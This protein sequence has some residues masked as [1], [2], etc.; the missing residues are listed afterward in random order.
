LILIENSQ[1]N[2]VTLFIN[3]D[4]VQDESIQTLLQNYCFADWVRSNGKET[5]GIVIGNI[6]RHQFFYCLIEKGTVTA[7]DQVRLT[8]IE[9]QMKSHHSKPIFTITHEYPKG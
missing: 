3:F 9:I 4:K 1:T 5:I 6:P 8:Q 7:V 2:F